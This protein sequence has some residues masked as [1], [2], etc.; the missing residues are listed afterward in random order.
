VATREPITVG[1]L[2]LGSER[3]GI[4][5]DGRM[6][7]LRLAERPG[8]RIVEYAVDITDGGLAAL[9]RLARARRALAAA[10]I[11]IVPYTPHRLWADGRM[12]LVQL[13]LTQLLLRGTV[14]VLHDIYPSR[15]WRSRNWWAL[16]LCALL[17]RAVIFHEQH[18]LTTLESIPRRARLYRVPLAVE[19]IS[20]PPRAQARDQLAVGQNAAILGMVGWLHPRKNC[21]R[22]IE[23]LARLPQ[24]A[25]LWLMGS[26]TPDT[27]YYRDQL[28]ALA[29][30]RGVAERL[31]ITGYISDQE[32]S[33]RLAAIDVALVPYAAISASA[34]LSTLIGARRPVLAS[35]LAVTRELHDQAPD[36]IR[37]A[38]DPAAMAALVESVVADPPGED[39]FAPILSARAPDTIAASLERICRDVRVTGRGVRT[40]TTKVDDRC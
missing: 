8:V 11:T 39:A 23:V 37:L 29:S 40:A 19:P 25:Q 6:L 9:P 31:T 28:E 16:T 38:D 24:Q 36:A 2:H 17:S 21:E 33:C 12:H 5:R 1:F 13:V 27:A 20:L 26:T 10:D 15:P 4:H 22:A 14:T 30:E 35:D 34:S 18:E 7:A 32:L 3:G